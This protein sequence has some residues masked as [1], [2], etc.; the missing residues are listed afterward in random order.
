MIWFLKWEILDINEKEILILTSSWV[1][2]SVNINEKIFANLSIKK[3]C[4]LFIYEQITE[5]S[6]NL[7]GFM[8]LDEKKVF[9]ELIKISWI[10]WKVAINIL[11]IWLDNLA[12][13]VVN[14]DNKAI[15]AVNWI[16]KK[17]ASKV[18]LELKDKD[19]IKSLAL[20]KISSWKEKKNISL[21]RSYD[22]IIES[23]VNMWFD[24]K[25]VIEVLSKKPEEIA[26]PEEIMPYVIRKIS[27]WE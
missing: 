19:I 12:E 11:N 16:W 7:F 24:E 2:Y 22:E 6:K 8:S 17:W 18:I 21:D 15:E 10:W 20:W 13:A 25:S 9:T 4:E 3:E 1:W 26:T 23:L 27:L 14:E 5:N